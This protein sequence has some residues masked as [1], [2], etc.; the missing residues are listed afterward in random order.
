MRCSYGSICVDLKS[1]YT[2]VLIVGFEIL[3]ENHTLKTMV[4]IR[5]I[6]TDRQTNKRTN[7]KKGGLTLVSMRTCL[8][9]CLFV[10][11]I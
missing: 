9:V 5:A 6:K 3:H 8:F 4:K 10:W 11:R 2:P 1:S 7:T